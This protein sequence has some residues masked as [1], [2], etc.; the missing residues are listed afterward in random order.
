MHCSKCGADNRAGARVCDG[1]GAQLEAQCPSCG[2]PARA[3]AR[4]CDSCGAAVGGVAQGTAVDCPPSK[5]TAAGERRHLTVLFCDLVGSTEIAARLDPEEWQE[6]I[7]D[8]HRAAAEA[9]TRFGGHVAQYLGDGVM[10]YFGYPEAH[11][12]NAERGVRAGLAVLDAISKLNEHPTRPR[13]SARVGLDSGSVVVGW[14]ASKNADVFGDTPN[15]AARVQGAALPNTVIITAD[16]YRLISG[17]FLVEDRG[18]QPLRGIERPRQLYRVIQPSSVRGRLEAAAA[19]RGLTRFVGR[20]DELRLLLNRWERV[21]EGEGQVALVI[22]EAG[23]GKSRLV[24]RFHEQIARTPH[25][26]VEAATAPFYQ[27]TPFYSVVEMLRDL[28][29]L[30]GNEPLEDQVER[31]ESALKMAGLK[32]GEVVPLISPLFNLPIRAKY[33]SSPLFP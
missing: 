18:A 33:L 24:H 32:P 31:L 26:W 29:A 16:V 23:I 11:E 6:I 3:G 15:I 27:N 22:G 2:R 4:F 30:R 17:L 7:A 10:A 1:C 20:E 9:I 19:T 5:T 25:T 28:L 13:L 14:G 8:Y 21:R 12:D